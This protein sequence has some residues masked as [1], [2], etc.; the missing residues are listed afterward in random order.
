[1]DKM[2]VLSSQFETLGYNLFELENLEY[3]NSDEAIGGGCTSCQVA[4]SPGGVVKN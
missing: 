4:C 1:M 2:K 3:L